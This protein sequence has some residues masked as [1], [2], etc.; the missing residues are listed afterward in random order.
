M[1]PIGL[2]EISSNYHTYFPARDVSYFLFPGKLVNSTRA[3]RTCVQKRHKPAYKLRT[4]HM[5]F[6]VIYALAHCLS[7]AEQVVF[8]FATVVAAE[9]V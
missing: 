8:L 7:K 6:S 3:G 1:T 2:D 4:L 5:L 9:N